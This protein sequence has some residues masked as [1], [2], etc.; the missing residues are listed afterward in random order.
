MVETATVY[1]GGGGCSVHWVFVSRDDSN[2]GGLVTPSIDIVLL[3]MML[4]F[5]TFG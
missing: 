1:G 2:G 5:T 3:L 4:S